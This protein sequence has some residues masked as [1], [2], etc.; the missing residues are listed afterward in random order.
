MAFQPDG[1]HP[2]RQ[3]NFEAPSLRTAPGIE[4]GKRGSGND[5]ILSFQITPISFGF[6]IRQR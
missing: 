5:L 6:L 3:L 4:K 1:I 2:Q